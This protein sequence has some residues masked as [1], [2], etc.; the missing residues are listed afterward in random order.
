[1]YIAEKS[2]D[3]YVCGGF[4]YFDLLVIYAEH[5]T[6]HSEQVLLKFYKKSHRTFTKLMQQT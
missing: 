2:R 1:M 3:A 5:L 6:H 4:L